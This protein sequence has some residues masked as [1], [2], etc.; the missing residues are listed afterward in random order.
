MTMRMMMIH[1]TCTRTIMTTA[2]L[3]PGSGPPKGSTG[4]LTSRATHK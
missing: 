2:K 3:T 4:K 1:F